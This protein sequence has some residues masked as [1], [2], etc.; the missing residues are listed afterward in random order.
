MGLTH[1]DVDSVNQ[2]FQNIG[3]TLMRQRM[4][5]DQT[6]ERAADRDLRVRQLDQQ[7]A[8]AK[9]QDDWHQTMLKSQQSQAALKQ[10]QD[11]YDQISRDYSKGVIEKAEAN[12]R[13]KAIV[14]NIRTS[15]DLLLKNSP[16]AKMLDSE[17]DLFADPAPA[18][19]IR[20]SNTPGYENYA[21]G[22]N[23]QLIE[24]R[25]EKPNPVQTAVDK[26]RGVKLAEQLDLAEQTV[27]SA[28]AALDTIK[29][30]VGGPFSSK[31]TVDK[32]N[33]ASLA[34][35]KQALQR[36]IA[37]R[38][39]LQTQLDGLTGKAKPAGD[40]PGKAGGNAPAATPPAQAT[41]QQRAD[42]LIQQF[43][44]TPISDPARRAAA[45]ARLKQMLNALGFSFN[46]SQA[47]TNAPASSGLFP[48]NAT[49]L[50]LAR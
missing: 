13:A 5:A 2:G 14:E 42:W 40:D 47:N 45:Q 21:V 1:A 32:K 9:R 46:E 25:Q 16:F 29:P 28:Q 33:A 11:A 10:L 35:K 41:A 31:A 6:A 4:M 24:P 12:R 44:S 34:E 7:D 48:P 15:T 3:N 19:D 26:A 36:A 43:N 8:Q 39:R 18:K 20:P 50:T 23:G 22:P 49:K 27:K 37:A 17:G 30:E 38:D